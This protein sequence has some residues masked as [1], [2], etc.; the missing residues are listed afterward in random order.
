VTDTLG[1]TASA[2]LP[3]TVKSQSARIDLA[4]EWGDIS[5]WQNGV[6]VTNPGETDTVTIRA[7]VHNLSTEATS[8]QGTVA[9]ADTYVTGNQG[10]IGLGSAVLPPIGPNGTATV[11][12]T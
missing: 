9:F 8:S 3:L 7:T 6:E 2:S 10:Q 11:E 5:F 12:L 1:R 4:L